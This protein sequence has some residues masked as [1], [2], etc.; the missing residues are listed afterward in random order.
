MGSVGHLLAPLFPAFL[1]NI[2]DI[3]VTEA[4]EMVV[5]EN[6]ALRNTTFAA[7][8]MHPALGVEL[9]LLLLAVPTLGTEM[10]HRLEVGGAAIGAVEGSS[11]AEGLE[12]MDAD[13]GVTGIG[14]AEA[15]RSI[16]THLLQMAKLC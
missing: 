11:S 1:S 2:Q 13:R 14:R 8:G 6:M 9:V 3:R 5:L 10:T 12:R 7:D 16:L 15:V 4:V